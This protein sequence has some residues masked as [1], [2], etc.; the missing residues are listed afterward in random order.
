MRPM[1]QLIFRTALSEVMHSIIAARVPERRIFLLGAMGGGPGWG[2]RLRPAAAAYPAAWIPG[3]GPGPKCR[4]RRALKGPK[5][6]NVEPGGPLKGPKGPNASFGKNKR[7]T[8]PTSPGWN[9]TKN[10]SFGT[11]G[12]INSQKFLPSGLKIENFILTRPR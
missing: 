6:P 1:T 3:L 2:L 12:V 9:W 11:F 10:L 8:P 7:P 4:T 5:G